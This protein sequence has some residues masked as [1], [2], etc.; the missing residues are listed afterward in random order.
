MVD[1]VELAARFAHHPPQGDA[2]IR[3]HVQIRV[4]FGE[5]ADAV[6]HL[7]PDCPERDKALD[8][9][10]LAAM[11]SNAAIARTQMEVKSDG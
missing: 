11:H 3:A 8:A 9:L 5:L 1:P 6:N 10:D 2:V 4:W 7:L